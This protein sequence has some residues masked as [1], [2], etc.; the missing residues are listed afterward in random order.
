MH[1]AAQT[2]R[3]PGQTMAIQGNQRRGFKF[4]AS[5]LG[6]RCLRSLDRRAQDCKGKSPC[7]FPVLWGVR[8]FPQT[9]S[10]PFRSRVSILSCCLLGTSAHKAMLTDLDWLGPNLNGKKHD[11]PEA[12][13]EAAFWRWHSM[14]PAAPCRYRRRRATCGSLWRRQ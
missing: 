11:D 13:R 3:R 12:N 2:P 14:E 5:A 6:Q 8:P 7:C 9:S 1:C 4:Y 10:R